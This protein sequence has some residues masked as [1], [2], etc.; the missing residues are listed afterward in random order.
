MKPERWQQIDLDPLR[1]STPPRSVD[2]LREDPR[3]RLR[4]IGDARL[5]LEEIRFEVFSC[6]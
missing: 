3:T 5:E 4:D 6:L 2:C 1:E